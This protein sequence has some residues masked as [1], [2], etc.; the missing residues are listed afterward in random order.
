MSSAGSSAISNSLLERIKPAAGYFGIVFKDD[1]LLR[2]FAH[3]A[4][5]FLLGIELSLLSILN[6]GRKVKPCVFAAAAALFV[7]AADEFIQLFSG[8]HASIADVLLDFSGSVFG[9]AAVWT[10]L[11]IIKKR[12]KSS[13]A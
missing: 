8:R 13:D 6:F 10:V 11:V 12:I 5:F 2:K 9:I 4:E 1:L 7:A 3:F